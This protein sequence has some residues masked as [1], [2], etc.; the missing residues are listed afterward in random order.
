MNKLSVVVPIILVVA[1]GAFIVF[2]IQ[3][4]G[5]PSQGST[6][7]VIP[8][9]TPEE[10]MVQ[11]ELVI[12]LL[13]QNGSGESGIATLTEHSGQ[14]TVVIDLD[15]APVDISQP[16]HIHEG[17]CAELGGVNYPLTNVS[18]GN[19]ETIVGASL[20]QLQEEL[21][22]AINVHKSG[23]EIDVYIACGDL[24][25]DMM[26]G[27]EGGVMMKQGEILAMAME[28]ATS[29]I[30]ELTAV[31]GSDSSGTAYLLAKDEVV[32]HAVTASM[33]DPSEGNVYEGWLVQ[34]PPPDSKAAI[35]FISTGVM[36]KDDQGMW[37]L[38][39]TTDN[40]AF[41]SYTDV[42]ITE[43]TIVDATP[44]IHILEGSF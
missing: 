31:D 28:D 40:S 15:G 42:V 39:Y 13:E 18:D 27:G 5:S 32:Y 16:A 35:R 4:S 30:I 26:M 21:P 2:A 36:E 12:G 43:E 9:V 14:T 3:Q 29:Q 10:T 8:L 7:E 38:E 17:S 25:A 33:P 22:L 23:P 11:K 37:Q 34:A 19:S 24:P 44:E 1:I 41:F 20:E 6:P